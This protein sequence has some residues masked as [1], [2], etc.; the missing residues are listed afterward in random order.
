MKDLIL[1]AI[2]LLILGVAAYAVIKAKK[3]GKKCVGCPESGCSSCNCGCGN[4]QKL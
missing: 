4:K 1:I 2:L 3:S